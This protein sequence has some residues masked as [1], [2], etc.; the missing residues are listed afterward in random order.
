M[1]L[2]AGI[3][4]ISVIEVVL[5][6]LSAAFETIMRRININKVHAIKASSMPVHKNF[7][8]NREHVLYQCSVFFYKYFKRSDIHGLHYITDKNNHLAWRVFWA[9]TVLTS[10]IFCLIL[11]FDV[12]KHAELNPIE[13]RVDD[14]IWNLEDV[15]FFDKFF[16]FKIHFAFPDTISFSNYLLRHEHGKIQRL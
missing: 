8:V 10:T 12:T 4:M 9:I 16:C 11:I 3:S 5:K 7:F 1:G 15:S 2:F 14:R 13:L 6:T